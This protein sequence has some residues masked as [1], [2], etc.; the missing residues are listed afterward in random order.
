[1]VEHNNLAM[2][3]QHNLILYLPNRLTKKAVSLIGM[4]LLLV[5]TSGCE[6]KQASIDSS[7]NTY[8][9]RIANVQQ[10]D[11]HSLPHIRAQQLADK[12]QLLIPIDP[13]SLGLLDSYQLRYCGLFDLIAERNSILGKVQDDFRNL[14]YQASL[15]KGLARCVVEPKID[16]ALRQRLTSIRTQKKTELTAHWN[17]LLFTSEAMRAQLASHRW[18]WSKQDYGTIKQALVVLNHWHKYV[19]DPDTEQAPDPIT[20]YQQTF[21]TMPLLG[22]LYFSMT[23]LTDWLTILTNQ[24][25]SHDNLMLCGQ[26]RDPT[27]VAR[28]QNVFRKFYIGEIQ[29]YLAQVDGAYMN[30]AGVLSPFDQPNSPFPIKKVHQAFRQATLDHVAYWQDLFKRCGIKVGQ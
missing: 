29:P 11:P 7:L 9:E 5:T 3:S 27:K 12:R 19:Q 28:L 1:M 20:P 23:N 24:L 21:E 10:V 13:I 2:V 17:N 14:D 26:H 30:I 4:T 18:Y 16:L 15:Y 25:Q 22:D 6:P 8:L